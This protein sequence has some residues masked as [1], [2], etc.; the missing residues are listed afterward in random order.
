M[1]SIILCSLDN[2][3]IP[4]Y[5]EVR[6]DRNCY[7]TAALAAAMEIEEVNLKAAA[8]KEFKSSSLGSMLALTLCLIILL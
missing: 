7:F 2:R 6:L 5:T 4:E 3:N 1:H 8:E